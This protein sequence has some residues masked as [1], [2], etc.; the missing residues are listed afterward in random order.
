MS[1]RPNK[2][3]GFLV[4][5]GD[6]IPES[7]AID[8]KDE[9]VSGILVPSD[10]TKRAVLNAGVDEKKVHIVPHGVDTSIFYKKA[11]VDKNFEGLK[12]SKK[13]TFVFNKGWAYGVN[14]R[15]GF[16]IL[17]KAYSEEFSK[18]EP[19]RLLVHINRAYCPPE[20]N[21]GMEMLKLDLP[22]ERAGIIS[23]ENQ[24]PFNKIADLYN[25]GDFIVS[26]S[27][28][29]SFNLTILEGM[30]CGLI[31]IVPELSGETQYVNNQNGYVYWAKEEI[32]AFG[33]GMYDETKWRLPDK[34]SLKTVLRQAFND[35]KAGNVLK[36]AV[37]VQTV[38]EYSWKNS[39]KK[40]L[41]VVL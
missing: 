14:D 5:E 21:F 18:D 25:V 39:G 12:D 28:A 38:Q 6:R 31:P 22:K 40:L 8:C 1:D 11:E 32:P 3:Y 17:A 34:E 20:W 29:E 13:C 10:H 2:F 26:S 16:D 19:V 24:I 30:A 36:V 9:R 41:S 4:F 33:G 27:K 35:W 7:W 23:I 37:G 15:S